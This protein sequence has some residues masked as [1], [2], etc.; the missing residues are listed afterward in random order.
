LVEIAA[1][2]TLPLGFGGKTVGSPGLRGKPLAVAVSVDPG[3]SGYGL[4]RMVEVLVMPEWRRVR[5][6]GVQKERVFSVRDLRGGHEE[7]VDPDAVDGA[8]AILTG[9]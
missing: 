6:R 7:S 3:D 2:G 8:F 9:I 4:L 1:S 5:R